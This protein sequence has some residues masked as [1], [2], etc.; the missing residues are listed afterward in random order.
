M[1]KSEKFLY[2]IL[3]FLII[4]IWKYVM[5]LELK[6]DMV[7]I[8]DGTFG[9]ILTVIF[10]IVFLAFNMAIHGKYQDDQKPNT[11]K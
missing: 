2:H 6:P 10:F 9:A 1:T 3:T 11:I 5:N 7:R 4:P 8:G